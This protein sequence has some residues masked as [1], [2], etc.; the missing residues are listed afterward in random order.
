MALEGRQL[1]VGD[2]GDLDPV[3]RRLLLGRQVVEVAA[4]VEDGRDHVHRIRR[5]PCLG[6]ALD[7]P[8]GGVADADVV[9]MPGHSVRPEGDDGGWPAVGK[10][11]GDVVHEPVEG[12]VR[13]ASV[14]VAVEE[15]DLVE[16]DRLG[17][18]DQLSLT[19]IAETPDPACRPGVPAS[20]RVTTSSRVVS[21]AACAAASAPAQPK[22]SSSGCA[23][24]AA[25][26]PGAIS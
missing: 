10:P 26:P 23:S 1:A 16:A 25:R 24:T 22:L 14:G 17:R 21:L 12:L 4:G 9:G 18:A 15:G 11:R 7:R 13:D 19:L 6:E 5:D 20:P 8:A 2:V 3:G